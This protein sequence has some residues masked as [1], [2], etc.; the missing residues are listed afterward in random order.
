M[1]KALA[2]HREIDAVCPKCGRKLG[3]VIVEAGQTKDVACHKCG[4]VARYEVAR[5]GDSALKVTM[6]GVVNF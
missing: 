3:K 5:D 6:R 4:H 2:T 1:A